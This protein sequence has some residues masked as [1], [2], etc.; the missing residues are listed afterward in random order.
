MLRKGLVPK[1]FECPRMIKAVIGDKIEPEGFVKHSQYLRLFT[2]ALLRAAMTNVYYYIQRIAARDG[3][4]SLP[5]DTIISAEGIETR[6][7]PP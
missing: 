1:I 3:T 4:A 7:K 5:S 2:R 6:N